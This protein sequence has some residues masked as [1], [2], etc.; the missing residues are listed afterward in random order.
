VSDH[1]AKEAARLLADDTLKLAFDAVRLDALEAL[2]A[3]DADDKTMILRLQSR[4]AS[5][6][7]IRAEL[8][9]AILRQGEAP[10]EASPYA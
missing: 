9:A 5:I 8:R 6:D 2:A 1:Y 4:V 7:D 3:A 10:N